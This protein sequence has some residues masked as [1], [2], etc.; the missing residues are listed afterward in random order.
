M[1]TPSKAIRLNKAFEH[2]RG[3]TGY[4]MIAA[5]CLQDACP[6]AWPAM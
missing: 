5:A 3:S 2:D 6:I 4:R 1:F